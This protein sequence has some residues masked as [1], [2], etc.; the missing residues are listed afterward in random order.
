[1]RSRKRSPRSSGLW[2]TEHA[3]RVRAVSVLIHPLDLPAQRREPAGK[4][5]V[6]GSG[7]A[8]I[9]NLDQ[10]IQILGVKSLGIEPEAGEDLRAI[11]AVRP[12][13][14]FLESIVATDEPVDPI[15]VELDDQVLEDPSPLVVGLLRPRSK[16]RLERAISTISSGAP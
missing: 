8:L 5:R 3:T 1:M 4:G 11:D 16:A 15:G 10:P 9:Q 12:R 2:R 13:T 14:Q 7:Q 6:L